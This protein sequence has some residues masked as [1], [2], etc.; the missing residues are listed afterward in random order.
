MCIYI[1]IYIYVYMYTIH[2]YVYGSLDF[3]LGQ[4]NPMMFRVLT[5]LVGTMERNTQTNK[6]TYCLEMFEN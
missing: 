3:G 1:Y 5:A 4:T 6:T 2:V